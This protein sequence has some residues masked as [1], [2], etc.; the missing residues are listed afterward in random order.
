MGTGL[1]RVCRFLWIG[2]RVVFRWRGD[3]GGLRLALRRRGMNLI[4][5]N[6]AQ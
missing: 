3:R 4:F 5:M 1:R 6:M 2:R